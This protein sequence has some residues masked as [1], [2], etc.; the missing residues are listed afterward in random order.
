MSDPKIFDKITVMINRSISRQVLAGFKEIGVRDLA[1]TGARVIII[2]EHK[3]MILR[4]VKED[5][6]DTPM[7]IIS[8]LVPPE[9][10][11]AV[12]NLVIDWGD[13]TLQGRGSVYMEEVTVPAAHDVFKEV[14][15]LRVDLEKPGRSLQLLHKVCCIVQRGQGT[16]MAKVALYTGAGVPA[17]YFGNGTGVR[18]KMGLLR[19]TIPAEKEIVAL[20]TTPHNAEIVMGMMIDMGRLDQPGKGFIYTSALK[21]GMVDLQVI[22]GERRHAAT[23]EQIVAAI[24]QI[25]GDTAWRRWAGSET[26]ARVRRRRYL[27]DLVDMKLFCNAGTGVELV[28]KAMEAGVPG[29]TINT[30]RHIHDADSALARIGLSRDACSMVIPSGLVPQ[31]VLALEAAGAFTDRCFGQVQVRHIKKAFTYLPAHK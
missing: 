3:G 22:R 1:V 15:P 24:D 25:R 21:K 14:E 17:V 28:R 12:L 6:V 13:L 11:D 26:G 29:A 9:A 31:A 16:A 23:I 8:C 4:R 20:C 5:L 2:R 10:A 30:L 19:I 18:D 27:T 7:D